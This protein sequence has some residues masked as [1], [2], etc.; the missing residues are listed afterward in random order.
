VGIRYTER[1]YREMQRVP[2]FAVQRFNL[3]FCHKFVAC[4]NHDDQGDLTREQIVTLDQTFRPWS[5]TQFGPKNITGVTNYV[6]QVL[7]ALVPLQGQ[8]A[9]GRH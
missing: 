5:L 6:L 3:Y 8:F 2:A 1:Y 9:R 7:G 4:G